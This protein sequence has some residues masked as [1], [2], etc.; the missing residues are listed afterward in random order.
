MNKASSTSDE[1]IHRCKTCG[2]YGTVADFY[3]GDSSFCSLA[4]KTQYSEK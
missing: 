3:G 4:C 1:A 2:T